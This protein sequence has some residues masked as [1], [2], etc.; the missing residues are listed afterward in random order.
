MKDSKGK[1]A[2]KTVGKYVYLNMGK[3]DNLLFFAY[4][5]GNEMHHVFDN[6]FF[7]DKFI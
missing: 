6:R 5:L 7:Q 2:A 3:I 1:H 4:T